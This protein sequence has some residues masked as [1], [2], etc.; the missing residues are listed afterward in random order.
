MDTALQIPKTALSLASR[1]LPE[2]NL[3][4]GY[5]GYKKKQGLGVFGRA[6]FWQMLLLPEGF[7]KGCIRIHKLDSPPG[8]VWRPV[9]GLFWEF[10][11]LSPH[12]I[13]LFPCCIQ[14]SQLHG[15]GLVR[16][17]LSRGCTGRVFAR[18]VHLRRFLV[19]L[20]LKAVSLRKSIR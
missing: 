4:C 12:R 9:R 11:R 3:I 18:C 10:A 17:G 16:D 13:H 15:C 5:K 19:A 8:A 7:P 14:R 20:P 6:G 1:R 2:M